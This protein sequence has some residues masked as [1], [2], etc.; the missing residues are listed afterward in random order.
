VGAPA[1]EVRGLVKRYGEKTAVDGLDLTV[2]EGAFWGLLGPNGA[3][4]STTIGAIA[5]LVRPTAGTIK[6]FG[7]DAWREPAAARRL[8]GLCTQ[9]PNFDDFLGLE[10][11]LAYHA[12]YF[13]MD[14]GKALARA[15]ELLEF[16]DLSEY[17]KRRTSTLS[18]GMKRRLLLARALMHHPRLLILDE[19]TAG[20][21]VEIRRSLWEYVRRLNREEGVT[22]LLTTHYLEEAEALCD[23]ITV[24]DHGRVIE[25]DAPDALRDRYG[26][27]RAIVTLERDSPEATALA[28]RLGFAPDG[29]GRLVREGG[30]GAQATQALLRDLAGAGIAVADLELTRTRLE[31]VFVK[32]TARE[33]RGAGGGRP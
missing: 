30:D 2:P 28:A 11:I 8:I 23:P 33:G 22:V 4:K 13:G 1:I 31:D 32:L 9:E 7:H 25:Q 21:D 27:R 16:F 12:G 17:R 3:G 15:R 20:V 5:G 26:S 10:R 19:P 18:G 14:Y 6:V 24:I 29:K